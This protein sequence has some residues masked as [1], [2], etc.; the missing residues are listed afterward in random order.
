MLQIFLE[1]TGDYF[2]FSFLE[3]LMLGRWFLFAVLCK[4]ALFKGFGVIYKEAMHMQ[5]RHFMLMV[6][7]LM[8]KTCRNF[9]FIWLF[10]FLQKLG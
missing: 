4:M 7:I 8:K 2:S 6:I 3:L 9:V 10:K 5:F 1:G